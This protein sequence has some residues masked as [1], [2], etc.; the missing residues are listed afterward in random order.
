M[1]NR[2]GSKK[3]KDQNRGREK[4]SSAIARM[5]INKLTR[6]GKKNRRQ[7]N[8]HPLEASLKEGVSVWPESGIAPF[9]RK[10][11]FSEVWE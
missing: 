3:K 1:K 11:G 9:E 2:K 6:E 7:G 8:R 4:A 10:R 5:R